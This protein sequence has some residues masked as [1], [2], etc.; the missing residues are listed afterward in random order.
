VRLY[1]ETV[2]PGLNVSN[3]YHAAIF[4]SQS[5]S[6]ASGNMGRPRE[7]VLADF[8]ISGLADIYNSAMGIAQ[9]ERPGFSIRSSTSTTP[10]APAGPFVRFVEAVC[11]RVL[12]DRNIHPHAWAS[13]IKRALDGRDSANRQNHQA[14]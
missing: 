9:A 8:L 7:H 13:Q 5:S 2:V 3:F 12:G 1:I 10:G 4:I 11:V 14:E 6:P